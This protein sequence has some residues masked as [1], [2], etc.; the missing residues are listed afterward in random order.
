MDETQ[1]QR[2]VRPVFPSEPLDPNYP[3][4]SGTT[5]PLLSAVLAGFGVTSVV[6]ILVTSTRDDLPTAVAVAVA[7]FLLAVLF[8][9]HAIVFAIK[10]Q[11]SNY[12]PFLGLSRSTASLLHVEDVSDWVQGLERRWFAFFM[13]ALVSFYS[14]TA[15]FLGALAIVVWVYAGAAIGAVFV[16][17][18]LLIVVSTIVL[19][20]AGSSWADREKARWRRGQ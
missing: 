18:A 3:E 16:V 12:I 7:G 10:A 8:F 15:L 11:A 9:V 6:Q 20:A 2:Q 1:E 19:D 13:V 5:L 4:T 14:G 17:A